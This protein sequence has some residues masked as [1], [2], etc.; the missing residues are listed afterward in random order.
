MID[1]YKIYIDVRRQRDRQIL[2]MLE[3]IILVGEKIDRYESTMDDILVY[4]VD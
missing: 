4:T 1:K 2:W 3:N